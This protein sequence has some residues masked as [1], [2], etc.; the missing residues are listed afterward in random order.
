MLLKLVKE[1]KAQL[2]IMDILLTVKMHKILRSDTQEHM[3]IS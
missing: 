1:D 3:Y 2:N